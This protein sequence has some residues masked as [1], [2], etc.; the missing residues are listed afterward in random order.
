MRRLRMIAMAAAVPLSVGALLA[1]QAASAA[2]ASPVSVAFIFYNSPGRDSG[3]NASLRAEYVQLVNNTNHRVT[4]THWTLTDKAHHTFKFGRKTLPANGMVLVHTG[5]GRNQGFS[6]Y[7]GRHAYAWSNTGDT[8]VLKNA[9]GT[10]KS[11]CSYSDP[12]RRH[13]SH[14]C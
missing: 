6:V 4:I 7:W 5:S 3:S 1:P 14:K 13:L 12:H 11:R 10:V 2:P 8:A 9:G